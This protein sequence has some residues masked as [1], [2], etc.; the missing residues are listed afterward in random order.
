MR[1]VLVPCMMSLKAMSLEAPIRLCINCK[2]FKNPFWVDPMYGK[3]AV[4][5][6]QSYDTYPVIG[7]DRQGPEDY[8]RCYVARAIDS[9]CGKQGK[10]FQPKSD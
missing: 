8:T 1:V 5:K 6:R 10:C 3:C 4:F 7:S 2:H 9:L